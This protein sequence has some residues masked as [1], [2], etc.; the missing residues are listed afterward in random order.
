MF[1]PPQN[2]L[3]KNIPYLVLLENDSENIR[4]DQEIEINIF[5]WQ[6]KYL[7]SMF[8]KSLHIKALYKQSYFNFSCGTWIFP[9]PMICESQC[10]Q[11]AKDVQ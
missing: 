10:F 3:L 4:T 5:Y 11:N 7:L 9:R 2:N 8:H 6:W 1:F